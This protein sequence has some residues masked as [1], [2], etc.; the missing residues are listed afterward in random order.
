[1]PTDKLYI[2]HIYTRNHVGRPV[3][4]DEEWKVK[5]VSFS[6]SLVGI[7]VVEYNGQPENGRV[8]FLSVEEFLEWYDE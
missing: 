7:K 1:M 4:R 5:L 2:H 8:T 6:V 3:D